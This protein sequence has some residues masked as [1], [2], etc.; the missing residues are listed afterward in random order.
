MLPPVVVPAA[1][2]L[3]AFRIIAE[4]D[5]S[6]V[7]RLPATVKLPDKVATLIDPVAVTAFKVIAAPL[8]KLTAPNAPSVPVPKAPT[9]IAAVP[10]VTVKSLAALAV[11]LTAPKVTA[12]FVVDRVV[13]P[14]NSTA[15]L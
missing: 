15:A 3:P 7:V 14:V 2:D 4:S 10:V 1:V 11:E 5:V 6:V 13:S 9:V 8:V 12:L